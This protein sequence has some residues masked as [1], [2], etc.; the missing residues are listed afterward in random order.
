MKGMEKLVWGCWQKLVIKWS[1]GEFWG[2][3][4]LSYRSGK[5][6][7]DFKLGQEMMRFVFLT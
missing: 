5:L 4:P 6:L 1:Y 3:C 7:G 2:F